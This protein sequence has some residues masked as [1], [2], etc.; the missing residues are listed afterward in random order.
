VKN[1]EDAADEIVLTAPR[2]LIRIRRS[3]ASCSVLWIKRIDQRMHHRTVSKNTLSGT[4]PVRARADR[5]P[6]LVKSPAM[7]INRAAGH[8]L[9]HRNVKSTPALDRPSF[10]RERSRAVT[11]TGRLG[12]DQNSS[13]A[14]RL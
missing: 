5:C 9:V 3:V 1:V 12:Y 7:Q 4:L 2:Q 6:Y 14:W 13:Q 8:V 11:A 10:P